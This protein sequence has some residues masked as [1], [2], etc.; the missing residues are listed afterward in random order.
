MIHHPTNKLSQ[1]AG[2]CPVSLSNHYVITIITT[3][4]CAVK[5]CRILSWSLSNLTIIYFRA[6]NFSFSFTTQTSL[7]P[8]ALH[9]PSPASFTLLYH[10]QMTSIFWPDGC[11]DYLWRHISKYLK[12]QNKANNV[13]FI[14]Y[15]KRLCT[16]V[17]FSALAT[18][19]G[20]RPPESY[21]WCRLYF[22]VKR[23]KSR[24]YLKTYHFS[25]NNTIA[26]CKEK[27][28][29]TFRTFSGIFST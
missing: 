6:D 19:P 17:Y 23:Q 12:Q 25:I 15:L 9:P 13:T 1:T 26:Q 21:S 28:I 16:I 20:S 29:W 5:C 22:T 8:D 2:V 24:S 4:Y 27:L 11:S 18:V 14:F 7:K 10:A 3:Y